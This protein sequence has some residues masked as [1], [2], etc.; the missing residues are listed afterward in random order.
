[1]ALPALSET[2]SSSKGAKSKGVFVLSLAPLNLYP[3][4][5]AMSRDYSTGARGGSEAYS[6][7]VLS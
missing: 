1:M 3:V 5:F 4:E 2:L 6:T 7:G